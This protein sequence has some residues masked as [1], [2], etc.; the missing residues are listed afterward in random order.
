MFIFLITAAFS[1]LIHEGGHAFT[2]WL[3]DIPIHQVVWGKGPLLFR[4]KALECHLIPLSG[5]VAPAGPLYVQSKWKGTVIALA[6]IA[7][8]WFIVGLIL[9]TQ[10][11]Q[12][13]W[14]REWS[15]D[16]TFWAFVGLLEL[17]PLGKRDGAW[18]RKI[19]SH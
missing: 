18:L 6:G 11:V 14:L 9:L 3:F 7:A 8:Q 1:V 15:I 16:W 2:H 5:Y 10:A 4:W 19:W 13:A 17:V 12:V